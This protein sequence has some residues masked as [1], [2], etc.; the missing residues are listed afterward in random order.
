MNTQNNT[1]LIQTEEIISER[2]SKPV[3]TCVDTALQLFFMDLQGQQP[4]ELYEMV[5]QEVEAPLLRHVMTY[6][7][8]NQSK[9]ARMLGLNRATLRKKLEK[10]DLNT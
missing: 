2:R 4:T 8:G 1:A 3:A 6:T 10:Y 5:L 7:R 9:A